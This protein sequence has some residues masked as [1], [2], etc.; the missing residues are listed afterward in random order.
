LISRAVHWRNPAGHF[1]DLQFERFASLTDPH[2][3]SLRCQVTPVD[4]SGPLKVQAGLQIG[5]AMS[6][7]R[8]ST[9]S[10]WKTT[11]L[12]KTVGEII[13]RRRDNK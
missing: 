12:H 7:A 2:V 1:V 9:L 5:S 11:P 3:L 6:L 4:F 8:M 13:S 10:T